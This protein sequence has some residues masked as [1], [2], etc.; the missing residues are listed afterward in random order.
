MNQSPAI[1]LEDPH[2]ESTMPLLIAGFRN[3][4]AFSTQDFKHGIIAQWQRLGPMIGRNPGQLGGVAYGVAFDMFGDKTGFDYL[5]GVEISATS[6]LPEGFSR[7]QIPALTWAAFPH[8]LHASKFDETMHSALSR[9]L[10][11]SGYEPARGNDA[12]DFLERYGKGFD[13]ES[14]TGDMELWIPV[15]R[16]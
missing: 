15:Q 3:S 10:P 1:S 11:S 7:V 4:Y 16:R 6:S 5:A 13:P 8:K 2:V 14:G 9:W 12:P